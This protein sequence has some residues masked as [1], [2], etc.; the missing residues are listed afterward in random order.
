M[1]VPDFDVDLGP[2]LE[3][4]MAEH[5]AEVDRIAEGPWPPTFADTI[6]AL[7]RAGG[8]LHLA[9]RLFADASG[10]RSTPALRVLE[11]GMLPR[12]ASHRDAVELDPRIFAR[13]ADL[14]A[15]R[16]ELALDAE[17]ACVL[18]RYHRDV[19]RAGVTLD[20]AAQTR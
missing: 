12:L 5:R 2:E 10:S 18:D 1:T 9:E 7:E 20:A 3:A 14:V 15:R 16:D 4:G 8:R 13:I 19:V 11:A 17:Q 6:E